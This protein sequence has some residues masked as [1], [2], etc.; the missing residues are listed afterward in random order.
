M[1]AN[2]FYQYGH[3]AQRFE[4]PDSATPTVFSENNIAGQEFKDRQDSKPC[5]STAIKGVPALGF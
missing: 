3:A 5:V 1:F 4:I 2:R